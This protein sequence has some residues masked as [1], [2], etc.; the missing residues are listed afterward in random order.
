MQFVDL[1]GEFRSKDVDMYTKLL[2]STE[3]ESNY[4]TN[5]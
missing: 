5:D 3:H 4:N 1:I 2:A